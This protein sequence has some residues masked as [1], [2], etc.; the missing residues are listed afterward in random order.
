M[1]LLEFQIKLKVKNKSYKISVNDTMTIFLPVCGKFQ[2]FLS[3]FLSSVWL[4]HSRIFAMHFT[5]DIGAF[6]VVDTE[7][8]S[9]VY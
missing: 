9:Y 6:S 4:F 2:R 5:R 3:F 1:V 7:I 8:C